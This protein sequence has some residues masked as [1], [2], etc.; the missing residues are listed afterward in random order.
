[1]LICSSQK[2]DFS[3]KLF[4][5]YSEE[6]MGSSKERSAEVVR[7]ETTKEKRMGRIIIA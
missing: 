4:L 1:M 3:S 5:F 7:M 6:S 2:I